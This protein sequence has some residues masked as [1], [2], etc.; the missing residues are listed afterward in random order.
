MHDGK[1]NDRS[2]YWWD[3]LLRVF[4]FVY[5]WENTLQ[6]DQNYVWFVPLWTIMVIAAV[7]MFLE[8]PPS[9]ILVAANS[10]IGL[11]VVF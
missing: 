7:E 9:K 2:P 11:E 10:W 5:V 8:F 4:V 3:P 6:Y 1:D